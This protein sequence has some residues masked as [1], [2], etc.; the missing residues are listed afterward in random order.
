MQ[1]HAFCWKNIHHNLSEERCLL[2]F[3]LCHSAPQPVKGHAGVMPG[4]SLI[5]NQT[6]TMRKGER[7]KAT[8]VKGGKGDMS[9]R[10]R[11]V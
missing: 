5:G 3:S 6:Q 10:N 8:D 4:D 7:K 1:L 9:Q 2:C 11:Q